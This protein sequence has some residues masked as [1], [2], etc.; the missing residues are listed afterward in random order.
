MG[1]IVSIFDLSSIILSNLFDFSIKSFIW[2]LGEDVDGELYVLA[3]GI[4]SVVNTLGKIY[5]FVPKQ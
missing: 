5:K 3:N 2:A 1:F 4:N